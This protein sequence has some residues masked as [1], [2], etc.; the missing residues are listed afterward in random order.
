MQGYHYACGSRQL[1][2]FAKQSAHEQ[3][4]IVKK[5]QLWIGGRSVDPATDQWLE[6]VDPFSGKV[7]ASIPRANK[8][9]VSHAVAAADKAMKGRWGKMGASER[10]RLMRR[11]G[12]VISE[13]AQM[14][15]DIEVRDNG[16][17]MT[18]MSS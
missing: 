12:D 1:T 3:E 7:W 15:C 11:I 16:K 17:L 5:Y 9:D 8:T 18:E 14:L 4:V 13:N 2:S 10:G 6:S